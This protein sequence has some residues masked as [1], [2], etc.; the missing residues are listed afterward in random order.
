MNELPTKKNS[1]WTG[2]YIAVAGL[3]VLL[4]LFFYFFTQ[5]FA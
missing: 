4:I 2:W 5:K 3:L 1:S